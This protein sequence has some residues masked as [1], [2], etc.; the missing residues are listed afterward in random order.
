MD[1][2]VILSSKDAAPGPERRCCTLEYETSTS[3]SRGEDRNAAYIWPT[4]KRLAL[5]L[6]H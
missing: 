4:S 3:Q 6:V 5:S 1:E 2:G